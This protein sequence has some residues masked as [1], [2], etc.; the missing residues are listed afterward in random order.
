MTN[1]YLPSL[2]SEQ[3]LTSY[4]RQVN[5]YKMLSQEEENMLARRVSEEQDSS[6]AHILIT[7]HLRLVV[8]VAMSM[9]NYGV[10]LM[11]LISEGNIGLMH[12]VKKFNP[13]LGHRLSTYAI[14][15]IKAAMQ[16][17]VV[18]SWS[19]VKIG[20][21]AAQKKL[22]FNLSKIKNKIRTLHGEDAFSLSMQDVTQVSE[23]LNVSEKDVREMEQRVGKDVSL[24]APIDSDNENG[25]TM[26]ESLSDQSQNHEDILS[27][28]SD[29]D[30]KKKLLLEATENLNERERYIVSA[31]NLQDAPQT[32]EDLS[33]KFGISRERVRQ[34]EARA[35]EKVKTYCLSSVQN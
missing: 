22:F 3:G 7:S 16:E 6:A 18:K 15:W 26:I 1:T 31:R 10:S 25:S 21:T 35:M 2:S 28:N 30:H 5:S 29:L 24:D 9:R 23:E 20:T 27:K 8:K 17:F 14:W 12:S 19:L 11:D 34:I 13:D 4:I 33:Q 32:L